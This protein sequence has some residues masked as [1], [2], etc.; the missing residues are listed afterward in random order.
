MTILIVDDSLDDLGTSGVGS[1]WNCHFKILIKKKK[2]SINEIEGLWY[3]QA[4]HHSISLKQTEI[5]E[6]VAW[7]VLVRGGRTGKGT[8]FP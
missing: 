2:K 1:V 4:E 7:V 6:L 3:S 8:E 5:T